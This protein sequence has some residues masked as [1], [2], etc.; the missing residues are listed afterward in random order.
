GNLFPI[1][2][3]STR[4][5][6]ERPPLCSSTTPKVS[7]LHPSRCPH[8]R[9]RHRHEHR[10]LQSDARSFPARPAVFRAATFGSHLRR[11]KGTRPETAAVFRPEI[12]ALSRWPKCF[13]EH[14]G[15]LGQRLHPDRNG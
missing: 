8:P 7:G 1:I 12:L 13:F 4:I 11:S 10:H 5:T 14:R 2:S 9:H 15:R 3:F 6:H